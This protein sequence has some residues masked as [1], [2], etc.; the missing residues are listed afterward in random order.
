MNK[1]HVLNELIVKVKSAILKHIDVQ[2]FNYKMLIIIYKS[3]FKLPLS[4]C[5]IAYKIFKCY[6]ML[7]LTR[8]IQIKS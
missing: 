4:A 3:H 6:K 8:Q 2:Y 1:E 7:H 5:L